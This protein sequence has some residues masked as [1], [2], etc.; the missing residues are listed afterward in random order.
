LSRKLKIEAHYLNVWTGE[1]HAQ[2]FSHGPTHELPTEFSV[3]MLPPAG[4]RTDWIYATTCMSQRADTKRI[5]LHFRS[6]TEDNTVVELLYAI[7]HFHRHGKKLDL[8]HTVNFGR[9]WAHKSNCEF[10][11]VSLPYLDGPNLELLSLKNETI[12]FYWIVPI[13]ESELDF[14]R[15]YGLDA[16]ERKFDEVGLHYADPTRSPVV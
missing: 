14:K 16:L 3:V 6:M 9:R 4:T 10:G 7:A 8:G 11:L 5:E 2:K 15:T 1:L 13:Y 12:H